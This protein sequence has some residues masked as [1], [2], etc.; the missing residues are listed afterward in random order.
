[1]EYGVQWRAPQAKLPLRFNT[2]FRMHGRGDLAGGFFVLVEHAIDGAGPK[3]RPTGDNDDE[4]DRLQ[5]H[6]QAAA[7]GRRRRAQP[8]PVAAGRP[9]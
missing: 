8:A 4:T 5:S 9:R 3:P 1:M 2:R 6:A 7:G